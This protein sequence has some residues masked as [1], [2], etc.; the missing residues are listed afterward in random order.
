M[1]LFVRDIAD[2]DI[3]S[4]IDRQLVEADAAWHFP[5]LALGLLA[6]VIFAVWTSPVWPGWRLSDRQG[7]ALKAAVIAVL[8]VMTISNVNYGTE[9]SNIPPLTRP[10]QPPR[11][12][13]TK[14]SI[15]GF[16]PGMPLDAAQR[17]IDKVVQAGV[18]ESCSRLTASVEYFRCGKET[19]RESIHVYFGPET[20][21]VIG[22]RLLF[23]AGGNS[24][25]VSAAI[26]QQ[27]GIRLVDLGRTWVFQSRYSADLGDGYG[28]S[29]LQQHN[30][31]W[32]LTISHPYF[33][34]AE[35]VA[36]DAR[37]NS[38]QPVP[39]VSGTE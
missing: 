22:V 15:Q 5:L 2:G 14:W 1:V 17:Q 28:I 12:I 21:T 13:E 29:L 24:G 16:Y 10:S 25:Q 31:G 9:P 33:S 35:H 34:Q 18:Y 32:A 38:E 26:N 7:Q 39:R 23:Y 6:I 36:R 3:V 8:V 11:F 4:W 20:Q 27:F 19:R 30:E 37:Q